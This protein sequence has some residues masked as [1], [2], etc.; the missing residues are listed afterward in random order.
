MRVLAIAAL[1]LMVLLGAVLLADPPQPPDVLRDTAPPEKPASPAKPWAEN[2]EALRKSGLEVMIVCDSTGSMAGMLFEFKTRLKTLIDTLAAVVPGARLGA[3]LYRD[4]KQYDPEDYDFTVK[5]M[6]LEP[7]DKEGV[8]RLLR[9]WRDAEAYGGGDVPEAVLD[10]VQTA[11]AKAGWTGVPT[12]REWRDDAAFTPRRTEK[13]APPDPKSSPR[14]M[15][16]VIGDAPPHPE[17]EGVEKT[18]ALCKAWK[19]AGGTLSCIDTTGAG[20]LMP[21][22]RKM[23]EAGDGEAFRLTDERQ[24]IQQTLI[25]VFGSA[26]K[27]DVEKAWDQANPPPP[28]ALAGN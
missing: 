20:K 22:F 12:D 13:K 10:G 2:V 26:Y 19:E 28:K 17:D 18:V 5:Y 11:A 27:A 9:F 4:K 3:V 6:Q 25:A 16:V 23:A 21:E 1:G 24:I 7:F 14:R 8:D 15:I